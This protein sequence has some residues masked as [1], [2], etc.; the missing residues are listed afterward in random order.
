MSIVDLE[1]KI[2]NNVDL[3][4]DKRLRGFQEEH[5][6]KNTPRA[7]TDEELLAKAAADAKAWQISLRRK[8]AKKEPNV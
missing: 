6:H 4:G 1:A 5:F 7:M 8:A 2:P 3:K